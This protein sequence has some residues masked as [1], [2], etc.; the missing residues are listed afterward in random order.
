MN[1]SSISNT[2][3]WEEILLTYYK[4][5]KLEVSYKAFAIACRY[6]A[7]HYKAKQDRYNDIVFGN[8]DIDVDQLMRD[9]EEIEEV[10]KFIKEHEFEFWLS[11]DDH[12]HLKSSLERFL[13]RIKYLLEYQEELDK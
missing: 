11:I 12:H 6:M 9:K 13:T 5:G 2:M 3:E 7:D 10:L 4:D 8:Q 1:L